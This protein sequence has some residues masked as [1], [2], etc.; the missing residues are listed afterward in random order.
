MMSDEQWWI[1]AI[2]KDSQPITVS[3]ELNL[4]EILGPENI[5]VSKTSMQWDALQLLP[6]LPNNTT[7]KQD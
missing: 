3:N 5:F 1:K 4:E 7:A 2:Q 6:N